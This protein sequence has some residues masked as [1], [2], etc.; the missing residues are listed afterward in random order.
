VGLA[1][2]AAG[3]G[4]VAA[5][6]QAD[7]G[8]WIAVVTTIGVATAL[9]VASTRYEYNLLEF[10]RTAAELERLLNRAEHETDPDEVLKL[11]LTAEAAISVENQA[12]MVKMS[13]ERATSA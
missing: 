9:H 3:L 11:A 12:W 4:F 7:L 1:V 8:N 13:E 10:L 6:T 5:G 2:L